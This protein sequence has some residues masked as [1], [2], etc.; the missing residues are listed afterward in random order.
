MR[1]LNASPK[2]RVRFWSIGNE[3]LLR[4]P[5]IIEKVHAY[6]MRIAPAMRKADPTI[7]IFVFDECEMRAAAFE[8]LC[9][10]RLDVTGKNPDGTWIVDGFTFHRYPHGKEFTRDDVIVNGP[11]DIRK[12]AR[13]LV[14]MMQRADQ[15]H[16]R[17]G[18]AR[19]SGG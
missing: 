5:D 17:T 1:R 2:T 16:G 15:K 19:L 4:E 13:E 3:P 8:A 12:Q 7:R 18:D 9:G 6:L 11:A 10:G 14:A